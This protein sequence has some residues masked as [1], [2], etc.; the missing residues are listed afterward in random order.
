M[1]NRG[2]NRMD[3]FRPTDRPKAYGTQKGIRSDSCR[4][5]SQIRIVINGYEKGY[6]FTSIRS[7]PIVSEDI[8]Y[9][10]VISGQY[11]TKYPAMS[12]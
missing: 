7:Y 1:S 2:E 4:I 6:G 12:C 10:T 8:P 5:R 11:S 3:Y 9:F